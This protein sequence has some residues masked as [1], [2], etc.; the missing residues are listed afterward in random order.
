MRFSLALSIPG[1]GCEKKAPERHTHGGNKWLEWVDRGWGG[2]PGEFAADFEVV[3]RDLFDCWWE[4]KEMGN[5]KFVLH[6]KSS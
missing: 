1:A 5:K 4:G 3:V 2:I 6:K